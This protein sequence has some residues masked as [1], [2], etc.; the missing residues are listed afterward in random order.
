M[1]GM[2]EN[3]ALMFVSPDSLD[4]EDIDIIGE[5]WLEVDGFEFP[6]KHW[7]DALFF[8][9]REWLE[10]L[11][12]LWSEQKRCGECFF[13]EWMYS[14]EVS[15]EGG[16]FILRCFCDP[17]SAR[18]CKWEGVIDLTTLLRQVLEAVAVIIEECRRRGWV[19]TEIEEFESRRVYLDGV[20]NPQSA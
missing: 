17:R 14:F 6:E 13:F 4:D 3:R 16:A 10:T 8:C 1:S 5:I 18:E 20:I 9:L 12:R 11:F 15:A 2:N 19:T 7:R